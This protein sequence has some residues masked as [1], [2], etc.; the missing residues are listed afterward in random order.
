MRGGA[1]VLAVAVLALAGCGSGAGTTVGGPATTPSTPAVTSTGPPP[2]TGPTQTLGPGQ[3]PTVS[4]CG[5]GAYKPS[6]LLVVCGVDTTMATGVTWTAWTVTAARGTGLVHLK[7]AGRAVTAMARLDLS[8][9][10]GGANGPQFSHL[11]IT[12]TGP[13]PDGHPAD[14]YSLAVGT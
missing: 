11:E 12:W 2:S 5:G 4:D 3:L 1:T 7:V 8:G 9:I 6:T 10:R 13:S 14:A